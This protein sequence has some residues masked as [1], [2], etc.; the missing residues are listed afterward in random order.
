MFF[1]YYN[2]IILQKSVAVHLV[3]IEPR[4]VA[5]RRLVR[6]PGFG[7]QDAVLN[8]RAFMRD[9]RDPGCQPVGDV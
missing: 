2:I 4:E 7:R 8:A 3:T 1:L 6:P 9:V 5:V